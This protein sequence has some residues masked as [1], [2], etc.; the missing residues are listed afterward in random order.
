MYS[1]NVSDH[2]HELSITV[3]KGFWV[4]KIVFKQKR[5]SKAQQWSW[6]GQE[7]RNGK[8]LFSCLIFESL[9][10]INIEWVTSALIFIFIWKF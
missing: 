8:S 9:P 4:F 2:L 7:R 10:E 3:F 1:M 6:D 5:S